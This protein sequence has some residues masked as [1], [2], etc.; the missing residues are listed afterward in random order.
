MIL[1]IQ[2]QPVHDALKA[3]PVE[4]DVFPVRAQ[5]EPG[6]LAGVG[7]VLLGAAIVRFLIAIGDG[8]Q[9]FFSG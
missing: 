1:G 8:N 9:L 6:Q 3:F 7:I 2:V 5:E 4:L